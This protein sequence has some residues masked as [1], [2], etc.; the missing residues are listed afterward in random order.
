M[1]DIKKGAFLMSRGIYDSPIWYEKP[2]WWF[3]VWIYIL[4]NVNHT[5]FQGFSRGEGFFTR[6]K[7]FL[8]CG[9]SKDGVKAKSID[10]VI[11]WLRERQDLTTQKTTRGIRI[12]V[13]NYEKYQDF[14]TYKNDTEN[15]LKTTQKRHRNDT[16]R[17]NDN[18]EEQKT[19]PID[20]FSFG[21]KFKE[22]WEEFAEQRKESKGG[23]TQRAEKMSL[24]KL[25]EFPDDI[26]IDIVENSIRNDWKGI[27][28][29][30]YEHLR[31]DRQEIKKSYSEWCKSIQQS[32]KSGSPLT[33]EQEI[34]ATL[35][36]KHLSSGLN[37]EEEKQFNLLLK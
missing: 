24:K 33:A 29:E 32:K 20:S 35:N 30:K 16:I 23:F 27:F 6:E 10:N 13:L 2:A 14:K 37:R 5:D 8:E 9:L 4:G 26:A 1:R 34:F 12:K 36:K 19:K 31:K 3:K 17:N 11:R 21:S 7:I 15:D 18:N 28:T 22:V 25:S